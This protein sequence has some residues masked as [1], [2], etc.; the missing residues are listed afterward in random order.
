MTFTTECEICQTSFEARTTIIKYCSPKCGKL[1]K[2]SK[3]KT[4]NEANKKDVEIAQCIVCQADFEKIVYNKVTCGEACH[5]TVKA[6]RDKQRAI[7]NRPEILCKTIDCKK[8]FVNE[9]IYTRYEYCPECRLQREP[10]KNFEEI[11]RNCSNK[12]VAPNANYKFCS[13]ECFKRHRR[14]T[15]P[16]EDPVLKKAYNKSYRAKHRDQLIRASRAYHAANKKYLNEQCAKYQQ[17]HH[18]EIVEQRRMAYRRDREKLCGDKRVWWKGLSR[19]EKDDYNAKRRVYWRKRI[20]G[21]HQLRLRCRLRSRIGKAL[22]DR[23]ITKSESSEKLLGCTLDEARAHLEST[24]TEGMSWDTLHL[25]HIDHILPVAMFNLEIIEEQMM[26]FNYRNLQMLWK[27][28]N[29]R[30]G[31]NIEEETITLTSV[32]LL[33]T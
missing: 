3:A 8:I 11:C 15:A 28:D 26:C 25:L 6:R 21:N 2:A 33:F 22:R 31:C 17:D 12:F 30:K 13:K 27:E 20:D 19:Q 23:S 16:K 32:Y 18:D 24:F 9:D 29:L 5:N 14:A 1:A 10:K 7:D 4:A